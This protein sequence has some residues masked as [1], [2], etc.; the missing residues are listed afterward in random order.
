MS[1][2]HGAAIFAPSN[3]LDLQ[4]VASL[5]QKGK[6]KQILVMTGAGTSTSAGIPD[7][8]SPDT[9][10]YANLQK[11]NLPYP[12]AIF[13]LDFFHEKPEPFFTLAKELFPGNYKPTLTHV[14]FRL[15]HEKQK[16]LRV[17]TQNI[18]TLE[19]AA[20]LPDEA[21]VEA[22]G[23][24]ASSKCTK[25]KTAVSTEDMR[26]SIMKGKVVRCEDAICKKKTAGK[27]GL[28]KPDIVFFGE[29][30]PD[31]FFQRLSDFQKADLLLVLGT[32]LQVQPFASLIDKVPDECP[33][34]LINL[35]RVGELANLSD[36]DGF[37]GRYNIGGFDFEGHSR[38]GKQN[39]RDVL[40]E[41]KCDDGVLELAM[42]CGWEVELLK[43]RDEVWEQWE[44]KY[45]KA[46][47]TPSST[48]AVSQ[49]EKKADSASDGPAKTDG[50][51][52]PTLEKPPL[53][54]AEQTANDL[55][56][57]LAEKMGNLKMKEGQA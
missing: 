13:Q 21:I 14:F 37:T 41:G 33:R 1:D 20:G 22:H 40:Y 34:M 3:K 44:R 16:L 9:G 43:L 49:A 28:V 12:E 27:G 19:R 47:S 32:S 2:S 36:M 6:A 53:S 31:R 18:D 30:L 57:D 8:R 29:G 7:F 55:A 23:S 46:P 25:C 56:S 5:I 54:F 51:S 4:G 24:F 45:K 39:A 10:L 17:F 26:A 52:K 48:A 15:L 11:Y 35:E 42:A 38:G 50:A